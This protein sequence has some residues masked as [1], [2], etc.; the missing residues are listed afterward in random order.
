MVQVDILIE[1]IYKDVLQSFFKI[2]LKKKEYYL[3]NYYIEMMSKEKDF[4]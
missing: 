2:I 4:F 3:K 1:E